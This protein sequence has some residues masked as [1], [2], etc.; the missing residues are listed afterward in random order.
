MTL[1]GE[2]LTKFNALAAESFPKTSPQNQVAIVLDGE[3]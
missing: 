1:K 2:G 3:V